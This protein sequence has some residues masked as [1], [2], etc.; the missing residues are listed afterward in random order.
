M[1]NG[2]SISINADFSYFAHPTAI[3]SPLAIHY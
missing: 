2:E 1:V 3:G